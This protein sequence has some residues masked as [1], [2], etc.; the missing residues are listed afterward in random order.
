MDQSEK[1]ITTAE[2]ISAL[3]HKMPI[4]VLDD[5][6]HRINSWLSSG[7]SHRK[8]FRKRRNLGG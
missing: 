3:S 5:V 6:M 4:H 2:R 7:G 1:N 8:C